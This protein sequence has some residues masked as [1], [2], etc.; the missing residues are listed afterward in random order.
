MKRTVDPRELIERCAKQCFII[1]ISS[2]SQHIIYAC[3]NEDLRS[4]NIDLY[5]LSSVLFKPKIILIFA[6]QVCGRSYKLLKTQKNRNTYYGT[7]VYRGVR[8]NMLY[9]VTDGSKSESE[10]RFSK[11]FHLEG[12]GL[13][14]RFS[15]NQAQGFRG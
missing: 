4:R 3:E 11:F 14:N 5:D 15:K 6:Q 1:Y 7:G 13:K 9:N 10:V 12:L 2:I 8:K